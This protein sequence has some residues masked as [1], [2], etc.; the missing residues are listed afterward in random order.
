[1]PEPELAVVVVFGYRLSFLDAIPLYL[2]GVVSELGRVLQQAIPTVIHSIRVYRAIHPFEGDNISGVTSKPSDGLLVRHA[3]DSRPCQ[4]Q[5]VRS[6]ESALFDFCYG[7]RQDQAGLIGRATIAH[8][9]IVCGSGLRWGHACKVDIVSVRCILEPVYPFLVVELPVIGIRSGDTGAVYFID[10]INQE[11]TMSERVM[12]NGQDGISQIADVGHILHVLP[13]H[14]VESRPCRREYS[15]SEPQH[16]VS[17]TLD[18]LDG[19][20]LP[21]LRL[22]L[23]SV[24]DQRRAC[25]QRVGGIGRNGVQSVVDLSRYLGR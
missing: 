7:F 15:G 25:D 10:I 16:A 12:A 1:M 21:V 22:Q 9:H 3:G 24:V 8:L 20:I 17:A 11:V 4:R 6:A 18:A 5:I 14:T 2:A 13:V 23:E 19:K